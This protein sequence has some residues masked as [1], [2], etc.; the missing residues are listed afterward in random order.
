ILYTGPITITNS[1][2]L[3]VKAFET[4]YNESVAASATFLIG[5]A[6]QPASA[7]FNSSG[8]F[9]LQAQGVAGTTY[10]LQSSSNLTDWVTVSTNLAPTDQFE[11]AVPILTN[12]PAQF[13]RLIGG[14]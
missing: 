10:L 9:Q 8:Q 6:I 7:T 11:L 13:Y 3:E 12:S 2:T 14:P 1:A 5:P 4:G